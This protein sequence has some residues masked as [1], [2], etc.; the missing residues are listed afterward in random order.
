MNKLEFIDWQKYKKDI[1]I[2]KIVNLINGHVY[3]GQTKEKFQRRYWLHRWKLRNG[4]HDNSYLQRAWNKYGEDNFS[5]IVIE[6][7]PIDKIDEREKYWIG[8]YRENGGCYSIQDGGQPENFNQYIRPEVRKVVGEK[9]RQRLLGSKL[10]D[11]TKRKMSESRKGKHPIRRNDVLT[12][13]QAK[14]IKEM[15]VAGFSSGEITK[16]T[17]LPYRGINSIISNN[18][19]SA[20]KVDGWDEYYAKRLLVKKKR[21]TR[22]EIMN[23]VSDSKNGMTDEE[24]MSKYNIRKCSVRRHIRLNK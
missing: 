20:I 14:I 4:T 6:V 16:T 8:Y 10:S 5:F 18:N 19:Y 17:G 9:N 3:V 21:L 7:L 1:G 23:L 13:E 22:D 2:Y 24:L 11:E 12:A 15:L